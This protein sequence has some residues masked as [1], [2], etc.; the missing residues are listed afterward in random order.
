[1]K[2]IDTIPFFI[3]NYQPSL[4]FLRDYYNEYPEIFK[5]YFAY[6][7]KDT[8]E[9]HHQS[10][11][12]YSQAFPTIKK[13]HENI[14]PII[15]E[16]ADEYNRIYQVSYPIEVNLIVG[17]FGSNAYSHRQII[18]N[19][20][21][22]LEKLSSETDHLRTIVAHEFGHAAHNI[23]SNKARTDWKQVQWT[24]PLIWLYQEGVA[25]HF[26]RMIATNLRPS[27]YF[28]FNDEGEDWLAFCESNKE[29]IKKAFVK[30]LTVENL[31]TLFRE[32]FSINGGNRFGYSRLAYFLGDMLFQDLIRMKGER[33]A[34]ISWKEQGFEEEI[35]SWLNQG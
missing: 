28:S 11:T 7:C 20:T 10:I 27:I 14:V 26:S 2:I 24:S 12:K 18:P 16:I 29:K 1:M 15:R 34:I 19:I 17:G 5:E 35:K 21:F 3:H 9:R 32:W 13:V 30:D 33:D 6:H 4:T 31:Q 25:T 8:E 22:A 23:L